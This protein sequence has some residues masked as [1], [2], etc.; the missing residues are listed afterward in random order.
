MESALRL[1][2]GALDGHF[3]AVMQAQT[4]HF[5]N[6]NWMVWVEGAEHVVGPVTAH[7]L[8]R[9]L[10]AGKVPMDASVQRQGDVWWRD[11]LEEPEVIEALTSL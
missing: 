6:P 7:Q 8:A 3:R 2:P 10:R 5:E 9:G 11:I 1:P 4:N